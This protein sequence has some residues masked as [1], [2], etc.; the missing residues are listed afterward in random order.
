MDSF[1]GYSGNDCIDRRGG[2]F[3]IDSGVGSAGRVGIESSRGDGNGRKA[4]ARVERN[5]FH[6]IFGW[7]EG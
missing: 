2:E 1:I 7:L 3:V 6:F 5:D 4:K